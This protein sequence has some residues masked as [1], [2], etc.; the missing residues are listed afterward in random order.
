M[1]PNEASIRTATRVFLAAILA[2]SAAVLGCIG[3][4]SSVADNGGIGGTGVSQ[5]GV[6]SFGSIF[7]NGIEWDLTGATITIDGVA[8]TESDLRV[9]MQVRVIGEIDPSGTTGVATSV[10]YDTTLMGPVASAP[11]LLVPDGSRVSLDVLGRTVIV[12]DADVSFGPGLSIA[13]LAQDQLLRISG[14]V[15]AG[16]T[17]RA[18][19][20]DLLGT[21][22]VAV[23]TEIEGIVSNLVKNPDGSGIFDV[24][25]ITVRYTAATPFSGTSAAA[26]ANGDAVDVSGDLRVSGTELDADEI[27]AVEDLFGTTDFEDIEIV[28]VVSNFVSNADFEVGG[29][30]VDASTATFEPAGLMIA[31]GMLLEVE[32]SLESGVLTATSVEDEDAEP[33]GSSSVAIEAELASIDTVARELVVLGVTVA[34]DGDTELEDERDGEANFGFDDLV[35]GDWIKVEGEQTAPGQA[36]A[37]SIKRKA[38]EADV[39]LKG[40]VTA[41]DPFAPS[42]DVAGQP[43]PVDGMTSYEDGLGNPRT[44]EEFFR[45]PGD[46]SLGS[47]VAVEDEAAVDPAALLEADTVS[48]D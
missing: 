26:L 48:I 37:A 23:A 47:S 29:V 13:T 19:R 14:H 43:I 7:V 11:T 38:A 44:E 45:T 31:D 10:T 22:P 27:E 18:T 2:A 42:L 32:G 17:V 28:G 3:S 9:N 35:V 1:R 15:E 39:R 8:A 12:D 30:S 20:I 33:G 4:D 36:L 6:D 5:G 24:G 16:G 40:P 41:L 34:A 21:F 46:V 25:P